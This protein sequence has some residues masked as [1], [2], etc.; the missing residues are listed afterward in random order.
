MKPSSFVFAGLLLIALLLL[1]RRLSRT[2]LAI[3]L[4]IAAWLVVRGTGVVHLPEFEHTARRIG[5]TL[6][7]WTYL[8]V[9]ALAFL[10]TAFFLGLIAPGE[11]A[12]ILGGFVAGQGEIDPFVLGVIVFICAA[13]GDTTS[14]L[15]GKRLGRGFLLRHGAGFGITH[16]RL[17]KV[18][19]FFEGHGNKTIL[20][21]RFLGLVRA[22]APFIA[23]ASRVPARRFLPID[24]LA[25]LIWSVTFVTLGYVFWRSFNMVVKIA[26]TGALGLG[27][28]VT[29]IVAG[30]IAYRWLEHEENRKRLRRA[31]RERSLK[32]LSDER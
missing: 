4:L 11:F 1:R 13:A 14:Y 32:P 31:W 24:Y 8:V 26:K 10:E 5:P 3:G 16:E 2:Q 30:V 18:E 28:L 22:L 6:G 9:G 23:G 29:V 25:A 21:G 27:A 17:E 12:V 20:I 15:L 19:H 7:A